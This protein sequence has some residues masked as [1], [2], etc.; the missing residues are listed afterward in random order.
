MFVF[1]GI[2]FAMLLGKAFHRNTSVE[3]EVGLLSAW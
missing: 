3:V 1:T 2:I